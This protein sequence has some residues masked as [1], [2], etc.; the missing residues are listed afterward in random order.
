MRTLVKAGSYYVEEPQHLT[1]H[2]KHKLIRDGKM[3][4]E[5]MVLNV[6]REPIEEHP[7]NA[8]SFLVQWVQ[9]Q[10]QGSPSNQSIISQWPGS[11]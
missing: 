11:T 7:A 9:K 10:R 6:D 8:R 2:E 1:Q 5:G 3:T 4:T